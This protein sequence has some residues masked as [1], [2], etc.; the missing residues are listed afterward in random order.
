[1]KYPNTLEEELKNRVGED[2]FKAFDYK[3]IIGKIDFCITLPNFENQIETFETQSLLWAEAKRGKSDIITSL[4]QLI[5]TIGKARTF[6]KILPPAFLGAFDAEKIVFIPYNDIQEVFYQNDFNWNVTPSNQNT[7]EFKQLQNTV[8]KTISQK[9][10]LFTFGKDDKEVKS[11]IKENFI[12]GK[13]G[14]SK[15]RIDKNNFISVFN[16]WLEAVKP[17]IAV[18]W[19][20]AKKTGIIAGDFYLADLLSQENNTLKENLFVWLK[21]DYYL[22]DR[23]IDEAGFFTSKRSEFKDKQK[24]HKEF[25]NKYERPPKE[26]YWDYII[27]RRDLLVPQDIRERKGSF[28]T[29]KIWVELSQKYLADVLGEDWQEEYY[30]WDCA[31]GTGNLLAGLTEKYRIWASTLDQQDV[32]VMKDRIQN[33]A[34]LLASHVFQFDFLNDDFSKIPDS[35]KEIIDDPE[36]RKKLI[37][38]IN[39]PY[40]EA[41]N[42]GKSKAGVSSTK[43]YTQFKKLVSFAVSD[44]ATQFLVRIY[45]EIP[46][47]KLASFNKLKFVSSQNFAKFRQYFQ[48]KYQKGFVCSAHTFDNVKGNFPIAF[49]I[50]DLS[51]KQEIKKIKCDVINNEGKRQGKKSFYAIKKEETINNWLRLFYNENEQR[52]LAYLRFVGPN[53]QVNNSVFF[54]NHPKQSDIK[55]S[56]IRVI[57]VKNILKMC[58]YLSIRHCTEA[59]WLNDKDQFLFP[60]NKWKKDTE[61]QNDC[62]VYALFHRQNQI[63]SEGAK[64]HWIPF[65][66]KEVDAKD[67]FSSNFMTKFIAGKIKIEGNGTLLESEKTRTEPLIFSPEAQAVFNAG[68]ELWKYYH[69]Q[70]H[71]N[72]NASLYDIRE[73]FQGRNKK[74]RMNS[75]SDDKTY[76]KLI[77]DLRDKLKIL[78]KKIEPKVYEYGFLKE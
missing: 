4:V 68:R 78:T 33:G 65:T 22:L 64:N 12:E 52:P 74:G 31:A 25:W 70:P 13:V 27:K 9:S 40:A 71:L 16:K 19:D 7:K 21:S 76:T 2:Y 73:Y 57:S 48:A 53:F 11:F 69:S 47:A 49:M 34:N 44:L 43:V 38:Y 77:N 54:T 55:E 59:N 8:E 26:E 20:F 29:P 37:I 61:F 75:K 28:F 5:L 1:M 23:K 51:K 18:N 63:S 30:I 67:K 41:A 56:R 46:D 45:H 10:L 60:K 36:E 72:V 66:E 50:W 17:S 32:D 42:Y 3:R 39:P 58:I 15:V 14:I 62:F 24:A 35:L 6:D